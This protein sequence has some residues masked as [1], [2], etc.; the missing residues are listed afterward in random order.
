MRIFGLLVACTVWSTLSATGLV[1]QFMGVYQSGGAG[2]G[3]QIPGW[4][5][6]PERRGETV[7]PNDAT[8]K[9]RN[10]PARLDA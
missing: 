5:V 6:Q 9:G 3:W 10:N 4:A 8:I 1:S 7:L 2:P